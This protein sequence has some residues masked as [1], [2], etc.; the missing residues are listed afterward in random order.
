MASA[1]FAVMRDMEKA[2]A[3]KKS[4]WECRASCIWQTVLLD[5]LPKFG[6]ELD[7]STNLLYSAHVECQK[8]D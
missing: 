7:E 6:R 1:S 5:I 3:I 2:E 4:G 8:E